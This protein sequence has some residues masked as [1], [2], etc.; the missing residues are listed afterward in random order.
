MIA[1]YLDKEYSGSQ[2]QTV[3]RQNKIFLYNRFYVKSVLLTKKR[4]FFV[5][6]DFT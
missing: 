1:D 6:V 3:L 2:I 4:N 5:K